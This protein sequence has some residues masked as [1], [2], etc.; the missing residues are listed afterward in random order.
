MLTNM[1]KT[2]KD[3]DRTKYLKSFRVL[4]GLRLVPDLRK[5]ALYVSRFIKS[6]NRAYFAKR[7]IL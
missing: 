5:G 3:A 2:Q 4:C 7:T 1:R 6:S